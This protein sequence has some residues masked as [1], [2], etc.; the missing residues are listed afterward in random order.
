MLQPFESA[1]AVYTVIQIS[2]K[3]WFGTS[4]VQNLYKE[5]LRYM[6][7]ISLVHISVRSF[8]SLALSEN[9]VLFRQISCSFCYDSRG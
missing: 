3:L 1:T 8:A 9:A 5:M 7:P 4:A 6:K 2:L